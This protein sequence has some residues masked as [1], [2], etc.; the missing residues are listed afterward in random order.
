MYYQKPLKKEFITTL[1]SWEKSSQ[2]IQAQLSIQSPSH[3]MS[4]LGYR[5]PTALEQQN[6]AEL[7]HHRKQSKKFK[8]L[9]EIFDIPS[10]R[11]TKVPTKIYKPTIREIANFLQ[12]YKGY[13]PYNI[14]Y[15]FMKNMKNWDFF[16]DEDSKQS[17]ESHSMKQK[18]ILAKE[19]KEHMVRHN[20]WISFYEWYKFSQHKARDSKMNIVKSE[21]S[22]L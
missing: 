20:Q 19:W 22:S 13:S 16:T 12:I 21:K 11:F 8:Q 6:Q 10:S 4:G 3:D 18:A 7:E 17:R 1:Y 5:N 14:Q 2:G 9:K 15:Q